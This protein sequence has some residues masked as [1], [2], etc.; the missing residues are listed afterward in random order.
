M[1]NIIIILLD[2]VVFINSIY[3]KCQYNIVLKFIFLQQYI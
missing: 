2:F 1:L 3:F